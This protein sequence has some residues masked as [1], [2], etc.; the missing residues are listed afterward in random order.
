MTETP[1]TPIGQPIGPPDGYFVE[2]SGAS[3]GGIDTDPFFGPDDG[4]DTEDTNFFPTNFNWPSVQVNFGDI[5]TNYEQQIHGIVRKYWITVDKET[6]KK[7]MT[8]GSTSY[9]LTKL[10][11]ESC[12]AGEDS[13]GSCGGSGEWKDEKYDNRYGGVFLYTED[14]PVNKNKDD[15]S[16]CG[17]LGGS[18][19]DVDSGYIYVL[20]FDKSEFEYY[21]MN[22]SKSEGRFKEPFDDSAFQTT[23]LYTD[24]KDKFG[25]HAPIY[26]M[27]TITKFLPDDRETVYVKYT[28]KLEAKVNNKKVNLENGQITIVHPVTQNTGSYGDKLQELLKYCN[29]SNPGDIDTDDFSQNYPINYPYTIISDGPPTERRTLDESDGSLKKGDVWYNPS[30]NQRQYYSVN[31]VPD[32]LKVEDSGKNYV[33]ATNVQTALIPPESERCNPREDTS[34]PYGISV[35][36]NTSN[37]KITSAKVSEEDYPNMS[38]YSDGDILSVQGGNGQGK[39]KIVIDSNKDNW[40]TDYIVEAI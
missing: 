16:T 22:S 28:V 17:T 5:S 12:N 20:V 30:S 4:D 34:L 23:P 39:L 15:R 11:I 40:T 7:T 14:T 27:D 29:F 37:G 21:T 9:E 33:D 36:I 38:N 6:G 25:K 3:Q 2:W 10:T 31:D 26:P 8:P 18:V 1:G 13:G 24:V 19:G 32:D 35:D